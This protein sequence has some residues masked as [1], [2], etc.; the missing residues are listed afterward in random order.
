M[1]E[2]VGEPTATNFANVDAA[3]EKDAAEP[4]GADHDGCG[5]SEQ[6]AAGPGDADEMAPARHVD[7]DLGDEV[8]LEDVPAEGADDGGDARNMVSAAVDEPHAAGTGD[9]DANEGREVSDA[10]DPLTATGSSMADVDDEADL[11][12]APVEEDAAGPPGDAATRE[13]VA[14]VAGDEVQLGQAR[15][16]FDDGS[17]VRDAA[18]ELHAPDRVAP[19]D[20]PDDFQARSAPAAAPRQDLLGILGPRGPPRSRS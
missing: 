16:K 11:R 13:P 17:K 1:S 6:S 12:R 5:V 18:I 19:P 4:S 2:A 14:A 7:L 15:A 3:D 10:V 8:P 20:D 9:A